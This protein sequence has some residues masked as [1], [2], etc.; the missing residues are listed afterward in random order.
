[1]LIHAQPDTVAIKTSVS[2]AVNTLA[3]SLDFSGERNKVIVDDFAFSTTAQIWHAQVGRGA[4]I[5]HI[6]E[7][8]NN[9]NNKK[10]RLIWVNL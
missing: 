1:M 4:E 6:P 8:D 5:V 2:D 10:V 9:T 3:S 7:T